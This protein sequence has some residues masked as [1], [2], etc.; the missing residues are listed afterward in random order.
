MRSARIRLALALLAATSMTQAAPAADPVRGK[1]LYETRCWIC[2]ETSVHSRSPRS[3]KTFEDVRG[4]VARWDKELGGGW[5]PEDI[6][7]VT[8]FL[9]G[10][11]Y[12]YPCPASVCKANQALAR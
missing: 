6:D 2:H 7:D 1:T 10:T 3:A 9:N 8:V 5:S 12:R 11:Y 4:F